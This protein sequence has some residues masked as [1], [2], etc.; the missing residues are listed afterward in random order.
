[1]VKKRR[2]HSAPT[3]AKSDR[4]GGAGK[5]QKNQARNEGSRMPYG[6]MRHDLDEISAESALFFYEVVI[7]IDMI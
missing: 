3:M 6:I 4:G 1:M 2:G 7:H 5:S